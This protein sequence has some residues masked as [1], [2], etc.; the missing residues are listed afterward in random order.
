VITNITWNKLGVIQSKS[1]M[2]IVIA[3]EPV[4]HWFRACSVP[5]ESSTGTDPARIGVVFYIA[6]DHQEKFRLEI[7][8]NERALSDANWFSI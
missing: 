2:T 8:L 3:Y 1:N 7:R 4:R 5:T 6:K